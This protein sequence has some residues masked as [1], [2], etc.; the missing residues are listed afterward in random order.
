MRSR[1]FTLLEVLV[2]MAIL[3]ITLG[4]IIK[5]VGSY[6]QN[7][8]YLKQ[9]TIAQWVAE[10]KAAE[11]YL[12]NKF[13]LPGQQEGTIEMAQQQWSWKVKITNTSDKNL[14]RLDIDVF[15]ESA[16][17]DSPLSSLISFIGKPL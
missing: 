3:T 11:Y 9:K 17:E 13:P 1:G 4:T 6:A 8:T 15:T 5:T 10:N 2:A 12:E 7:A 16:K 14:R